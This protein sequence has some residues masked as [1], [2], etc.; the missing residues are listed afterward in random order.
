MSRFFFN[1]L[2]PKPRI[3][4]A[5]IKRWARAALDLADDV[6]VSVSQVA[7]REAGCPDIETVI[8]VLKPGFNFATWR[9]LLPATQVTEADV[10]RA[11]AP[12]PSEPGPS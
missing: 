2:A 9:I 8:G 11:L 10:R 4:T 3:D 12:S 6:P 5:S 7:C 1:P